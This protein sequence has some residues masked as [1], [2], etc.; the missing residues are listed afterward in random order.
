[1]YYLVEINCKYKKRIH[2]LLKDL[3]LINQ[4]RKDLEEQYAL[5]KSKLNFQ[6]APKAAPKLAYKAVKGDAVDELFFHHL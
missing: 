4:K 1:M 6:P 2:D 5:L 3:R